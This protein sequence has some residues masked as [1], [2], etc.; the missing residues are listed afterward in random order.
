MQT[1]RLELG[2]WE[3]DAHSPLGPPGGFGEV[4]RGRGPASEVAVK[5][6]RISADDA[7][8]REMKIGAELYDR[9]LQHVVPVLDYGRDAESDR[10]FLIMPICDRS[11]QDTIDAAG[12]LTLEE[13]KSVTRDILNGLLE[14]GDIAHRDLKPG[15]ILW[16]EGK[17]K[18]ADFG[19]AKFIEEAT[20]IETLRGALTPA[21]AAPEQWRSERP[22]KSTDIYAL[23]C[24]I[25]TML[26]GQPPFG[27]A[28]DQQNHLYDPAPPLLIDDARFAGLVAMMLRKPALSRP[29]VERCVKVV[30]R[31][32]TQGASSARAQLAAVGAA[33][34]QANAEE[35]AARL[36]REAELAARHNLEESARSE[37][38]EIIDRLFDTIEHET[39]LCTRNNFHISLG[40]GS[41]GF[42]FP[43]S[44]SGSI[45]S[46]T[47]LLL[48]DH[49]TIPEFSEWDI[50]LGG[51]LHVQCDYKD[52]GKPRNYVFAS[53]IFYASSP[54]EKSFRWRE[55]SFYR[56]SAM[57]TGEDS[58]FA[59]NPFN[60]DFK[61]ALVSGLH[62]IM[63]A[64]GPV[65]IDGED[66]LAFQNR[67][68]NLFA[69]AA[70]GQLERPTQIPVPDSFFN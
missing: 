5:R 31:H 66:E 52:F 46:L 44:S 49:S 18:I 58:P 67:W 28:A 63:V 55:V 6:L 8:H 11:L 27:Y 64:H 9:K 10:Y 16:H 7:A 68:I 41:M 2:E 25:Y 40:K 54:G 23:G 62:N 48:I 22:T 38:I 21:Y 33:I 50:L 20:S 51:F 14:V 39:D 36:T 19:I 42:Q 12:T 37:M 1:I 69:R 47:E 57:P 3:F 45:L 34:A 35:E 32:D 26:Q 30:S 29:S 53:T 70:L 56:L 60:D 59:L 65:P 13:A 15:N 17:W 43:T 61:Y 24:I 4:F